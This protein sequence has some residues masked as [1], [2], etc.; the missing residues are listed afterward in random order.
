[1]LKSEAEAIQ[2]GFFI[3]SQP[4]LKITLVLQASVI[5]L[6]GNLSE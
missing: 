6:A 2:G 3:P 1:M 4:L 5:A